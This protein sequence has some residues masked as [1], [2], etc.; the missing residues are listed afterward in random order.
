[1]KERGRLLGQNTGEIEERLVELVGN[2]NPGPEAPPTR[3]RGRE[4]REQRRCQGRSDRQ[5]SDGEEYV[6]QGH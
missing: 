4:R 6:C 5:R 3:K 1:M 2:Q